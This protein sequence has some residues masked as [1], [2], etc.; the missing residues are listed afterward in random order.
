MD[1]EL[2]SLLLRAGPFLLFVLAAAETAFVTGLVVP[3]GVATALGAFLAS[4]GVLVLGEVAAGAG[5]GAAAGDSLGFWLGRRYGRS[6]LAGPG[7]LRGLARRQEPRA[8][9]L[10]GRHPIYAVSLAR[11]ASFVRTLMPM[12][13]GM[14]RISYRRFLVF[15]LVGIVAWGALYIGV[16]Y[17]ADR[18]WRRVSGALGTGWAV[19]FL[20]VGIGLWLAARRRTLR[21]PGE[22]RIFRPPPPEDGTGEEGGC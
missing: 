18:G 22:A 3:A 16:G 10:F 13:A 1:P 6:L 2:T 12:V 19:V 8:S 15:D 21:E 9:A 20:M 7:R 4:E 14:S 17:L 11:T 5:L